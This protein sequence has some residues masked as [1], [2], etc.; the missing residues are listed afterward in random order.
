MSI[1]AEPGRKASPYTDLRDWL[2]AVDALGE[3]RHVEGASWEEDIGRIAEM[4]HHTEE[5]PA[6]LFD[7]IPGYPRGYRVLVNSLGGRRRLAFT[8]GLDPELSTLELIDAWE[9]R[10]GRLDPMPV[11]QVGSGPILENVLE[12]ADIDL[13]RFPT[14]RWHPLDG[15]RYIGTGVADV[16]RDPDS[17]WINFGTYRVMI[18]DRSRCGLYISPGKHGRLHR[19]KYFARGEPMP[20]LAVVG[21][22]PILFLASCLEIPLGVSE[23]EW[24]GAVKG[25]PIEVIPGKYTGLPMPAH[26]EIVIEGFVHPNDRLIEGPFGEWTG[27][28]ASGSR[29][30]PVIEVK[31]IYHRHDPILLGCPPQ[32]PPYEAHH[33]RKYLRSAM[34]RKALKDAGVPGIVGAYCHPVG[35]CRL[36]YV[37]AIRQLY[38]GHAKQVGLLAS[39]VRAGA[40]MNRMVVVVDEDVDITDL[41]DVMWAVLTRADPAQDYEII[42]R[43]WSGPLD[44]AIHPDHKGF[45]S[46]VIIDATRPWEWRDRFPTAVGPEPEGKR[47]T[48]EK[49]G[50]ILETPPRTAAQP[51][52]GRS[53]SPRA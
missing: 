31:A 30:E 43:C 37:I 16:T 3:L 15:G 25:E 28:Y 7:A 1:T 19:D 29:E 27:Y 12:G 52:A 36:L 23:Y 39:Q 4:L 40:Y 41:N 46:R 44:P 22:D 18:H 26:A 47:E 10:L 5:S 45:N 2:Q 33:F 20:V 50:W 8:L 9:D 38:P 13:F 32:K 17:G 35:G 42:R 21:M 49:W 53:R 48:R 14:P 24:A 11:R 51:S 6:V 34:L